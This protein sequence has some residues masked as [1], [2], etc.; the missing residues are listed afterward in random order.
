LLELVGFI[1]D[2]ETDSEST[3]AIQET[4]I[5]VLNYDSFIFEGFEFLN[6]LINERLGKGSSYKKSNETMPGTS[7]DAGKTFDTS[8]DYHNK[9]VPM[10][11]K[12]RQACER[13]ANQEKTNKEL[14]Y[15][16]AQERQRRK[17]EQPYLYQDNPYTVKNIASKE[18]PTSIW[19]QL[20]FYRKE[21]KEKDS[22][23]PPRE[24]TVKDL[25]AMNKASSMNVGPNDIKRL[26]I[27]SLELTNNFRRTRGMPELTWNDE[28]YKLAMGHSQNMAEG[29]V[30]VGH[31]GFKDRMNK[32]P[33]HVRSFSENVAYNYNCSDPVE[34]AVVGWINSP[35]H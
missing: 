17:A 3:Y 30:P 11:Q 9:Y 4:D 25:E 24:I 33:F 8:E 5:Y 35:G 14:L 23:R 12:R 15:N 22:Y 2:K 6:S 7:K 21:K 1:L 19:D 29:K 20:R 26:G 10:N 32:V 16:L 13:L 28:L 31:D 18:A 34:T 27:R